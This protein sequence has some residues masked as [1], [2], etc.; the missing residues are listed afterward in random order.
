MLICSKIGKDILMHHRS[1][2]RVKALGEVFTP[3]EHIQDMLSIL[4]TNDNTIWEDPDRVFFEP[5]C[6]SGNIVVDILQHRLEGLRGHYTKQGTSNPDMYAAVTALTTLRAI[7]IDS[8]NVRECQERVSNLLCIFLDIQQLTGTLSTLLQTNI[9]KNEFFSFIPS[10]MGQVTVIGNPP[11]Q[12]S[13]GGFGGKSTTI[14]N[15]FYEACIKSPCVVETIMVIPARWFA[16]GKGLNK[17][18]SLIQES[19]SI[20]T[21]KYFKN[22]KDIFPTVDINGGVCFLHHNKRYTGHTTFI[23]GTSKTSVQLD[24]Y[25]I[26]LDD[27]LGYSIVDKILSK[28]KG[29]FIGDVAWAR[30]PYGLASNFFNKYPEQSGTKSAIPCLSVPRKIKYVLPDDIHKNVDT[31]MDW[32]VCV[33]KACGGSKGKRRSTVPLSQIFIVDAGTITTE[34]YS[35]I[36]TFSTKQEAE[37]FLAYLQTDFARYCVGLRKITQNL[38]RESWNWVPYMNIHKDIELFNLTKQEQTHI[39][40]KVKEWS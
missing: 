25:D 26:I 20:Q 9:T 22:S 21:I 12:E 18:R 13:D 36:D 5:C 34:T 15:L 27:P 1:R 37:A 28:H 16:G 7:D 35:V 2:Q 6:G 40:N 23:E 24:K 3:D 19:Q 29:K 31:I 39:K 30:K 32:K 17:F 11:Y 38:S 4:H 33:S 10:L 14:Y 8:T